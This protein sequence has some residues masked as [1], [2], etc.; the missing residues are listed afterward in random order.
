MVVP[1]IERASLDINSGSGRLLIAL[2]FF[3]FVAFGVVFLILGFKAQT[4]YARGLSSINPLGWTAAAF[5]MLLVLSNAQLRLK[6]SDPRS[7]LISCER[8]SLCSCNMQRMRLPGN[9]DFVPKRTPFSGRLF[10]RAFCRRAPR[11]C[12]IRVPHRAA[13]DECQNRWRLWPDPGNAALVLGNVRPSLPH[14]END[15]PDASLRLMRQQLQSCKFAWLQGCRS[16]VSI[17][18]AARLEE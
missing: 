3:V 11:A 5:V 15:F 2:G 12:H 16:R 6:G 17:A 14:P 9:P 4:E 18:A 10:I 7:P 1:G 8:Q 13:F